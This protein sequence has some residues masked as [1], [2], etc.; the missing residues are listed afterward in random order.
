MPPL[1][2]LE[3][4]LKF[5][6]FLLSF[7]AI[8]YTWFATRSKKVEALEGRVQRMESQIATMP[9]RDEVH[10]IKLKLAG[11]EGHL[12]QIQAMTAAQNDTMKRLDGTIAML[13]EHLMKAGK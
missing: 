12:G 1:D 4:G 7:G 2:L 6:G 5:A 10:D 3:F 13:Q 8:I 9:G 11:I